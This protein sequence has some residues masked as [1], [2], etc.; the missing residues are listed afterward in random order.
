MSL[1]RNDK[2]GGKL[3]HVAGDGDT[4]SKQIRL[5]YL[6]RRRPARWPHSL[7]R[8]HCF[9]ETYKNKGGAGTCFDEWIYLNPSSRPIQPHSPILPLVWPPFLRPTPPTDLLAGHQMLE[10]LGTMHERLCMGVMIR[11]KMLSA[12]FL[13]RGLPTWVTPRDPAVWMRSRALNPVRCGHRS[14][15]FSASSSNI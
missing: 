11:R 5:Y 12:S 2:P 14:N 7:V 8:N 4:Q 15:S 3:T 10:Q 13:R 9:C 1:I 6:N